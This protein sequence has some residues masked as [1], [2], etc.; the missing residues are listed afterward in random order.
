M[1]VVISNE[2]RTQ[3]S[4]R[5][6][7]F[8]DDA[9]L[10]GIPDDFLIDA[11]ITLF[12]PFTGLYLSAVDFDA[13]RMYFSDAVTQLRLAVC[14]YTT[15]SADVF[16]Y[17]G[18]ERRIGIVV[19]GQ[20]APIPGGSGILTFSPDQASLVPAVC[21]HLP[22]EGVRCV[23]LDSGEAVVGDVILAGEDGVVIY[24]AVGVANGIT[25][26][27]VG[28]PKPDFSDCVDGDE[29]PYIRDISVQVDSTFWGVERQTGT[30]YPRVVLSALNLNL[31]DICERQ[32]VKLPDADGNL[33]NTTTEPVNPENPDACEPPTP[34]ISAFTLSMYTL[35]G[36]F[37]IVTPDAPSDPN[38]LFVAPM[39]ESSSPRRV[40]LNATP[41]G[42]VQ[43]EI[44]AALNPPRPPGGLKLGI[45]GA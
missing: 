24:P 43:S 10:S 14:E 31:D 4:A 6:Y 21:R 36:F 16:E 3:N 34:V 29:R 42:Q 38:A 19:F 33:P 37:A 7:P 9:V 40:D 28:V 20:G 30:I 39:K 44:A 32:K 18:L 17:D 1:T 45:R 2:Y 25:I 8:S 23:V 22:M 26:D 15:G 27:I 5:K 41:Q 13:G 11:D 35:R 12:Q